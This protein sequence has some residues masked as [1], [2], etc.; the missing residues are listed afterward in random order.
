[1][2][3][4]VVN[5]AIE[6]EAKTILEEI[7]MEIK[8]KDHIAIVGR[9]GA[10]KTTLLSALIDNSLFREGVG[11]EKFQISKVG[12]MEVGFLKQNISYTENDTLESYI[13]DIYKDILEIEEKINELEKKISGG[14]ALESD[15]VKYSELYSYYQNIGGYDYKKEYLTALTKNGFLEKDLSRKISSFSGGEQTKINFVRLL[16]SK[17]D[18][19]LLDEPTNHLDIEAIL[20]L[21]DYLKN[22]PK[23][24]VLVSHDRTFINR[25]ANKIYEIEYGM[26]DLYVGNYDYFLEEKSRRYYALVK[27]YEKQQKE[28]QRLQRIVERF[29][30]KPSKASMAMSKL[31][32]IERM[33]LID[34]PKKENT[35]TFHV[36]FQDF[37]ESGRTVMNIN[38]LKYGYQ[39]ILG[40]VN[41][42]IEKGRRIGI[43][44][45]NGTGKSTF[46]KTIMGSVPCI[47]GN[48]ELG[49]HTKVAYFD[50][51]FASLNNNLT[52]YEEFSLSFPEMNE[53][54]KRSCLASFLFFEE[55]IHKKIE[56]LSGGEK[57]RLQLCK[58]IYSKANFLI[59]DEPTNHLDI[60]S[61]EKLEEILRA[62]PGTILFVSHD[63]Y[64]IKKLADAIIDFDDH[65]TYYDYGYED[66]LEK[67]KEKEL[68]TPVLEKVTM[69][70][71]KKKHINH[72]EALDKKIRELEKQIDEA[73]A[74]LFLEEVYSDPG[75][76]RELE[77]EIERLEDELNACLI[78]WC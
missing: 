40:E 78:K 73:K 61:K 25:V 34:K 54:E 36:K 33:N 15:M 39:N 29:R 35:A 64:F 14:D 41:L 32:Q 50:Q 1:M 2:Y 74:K 30:Y 77:E 65:N 27:S 47:S 43:V 38:H 69:K 4:K 13:L 56:V 53:L 63:R 21:E 42:T 3:F 10:G 5:G 23:A 71:D 51:Q 52:V 62:Y 11:E 16:L 72:S 45:A 12:R 46:L 20:W 48:V 6:K 28:I 67:R 60:Y 7:N 31:H 8:E 26:M 18:L 58:V 59:L 37:V 17:P 24:F 75:K 68:S 70:K 55:D 9:N 49:Y 19:L 57:V 76:Y 66:Y 22:Y 44:G